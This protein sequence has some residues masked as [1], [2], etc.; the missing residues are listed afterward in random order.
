MSDTLFNKIVVFVC[1]ELLMCLAVFFSIIDANMSYW[2]SETGIS[3]KNKSVHGSGLLNKVLYSLLMLLAF[4]FFK[5]GI[6]LRVMFV[7][8]CCYF[9]SLKT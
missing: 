7:L 4:L 5:L 9:S 1:C 6:S 8:F 3:A 2:F